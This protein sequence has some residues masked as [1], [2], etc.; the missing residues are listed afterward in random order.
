[1]V[2]A[3]TRFMSAAHAPDTESTATSSAALR[4]QKRI[5][6]VLPVK[7]WGLDADGQ[8]LS[9]PAHTLD[10][11]PHGA[12]IGGVTRRFKDNDIIGI[13]R[14]AMKTRCR[15]A[16]TTL[17][18]KTNLWEIGVELLEPEKNLWAVA[19]PAAEADNVRNPQ[20]RSPPSSS[21]DTRLG[22]ALSVHES[23]ERASAASS[24]EFEIEVIPPSEDGNAATS[25]AASAEINPD[26]A[27][28]DSS[29]EDKPQL[30]GASPCFD[31]AGEIDRSAAVPAQF[32]DSQLSAGHTDTQVVRLNEAVACDFGDIK[33]VI[34]RELSDIR[35]MVESR[36]TALESSFQRQ[37]ES[38]AAQLQAERSERI[39]MNNNV[40]NTLR[41]SSGLLS[42]QMAE[43]QSKTAGEHEMLRDNLGEIWVQ[44]QEDMEGL[45][46]EF[47]ALM[48]KKVEPPAV[49]TVN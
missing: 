39:E 49:K 13:A 6:S 46:E 4:R 7:I 32:Q 14:G 19:L 24:P 2:F 43:L 9:Q 22:S 36:L 23:S 34:A 11:T 45:R 37:T 12:R 47:N 17:N 35:K 21:I 16:W 48:D 33:D 26:A 29:I 15:V 30:R 3:Y 31:I 44:L 10:V 27:P 42:Q 41:D 28:V 8:A 20:R 5:K 18:E 38:L 25:M 40:T 1:M